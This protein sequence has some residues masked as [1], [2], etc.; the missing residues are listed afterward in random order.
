MSAAV[1]F[2][3]ILLHQDVAGT[4][5]IK[6]AGFCRLDRHGN[7]V[8][9]GESVSLG[10]NAGPQDAKILNELLRPADSVSSGNRAARKSRGWP[11]N[12]T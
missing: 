6:S 4:R 10:C 11:P 8:V 9:C 3:P 2:S 5:K 1:V 7:W 12:S